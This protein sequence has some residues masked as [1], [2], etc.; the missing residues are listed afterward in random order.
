MPELQQATFAGGCFWCMEPPFEKLDGVAEVAAGYTGGPSTSLGAPSRASSRD[1]GAGRPTYEEVS[2]GATGH[3]EAVRITYDPSRVSY[4]ELLETFWRNIDPTQADGQFADKGSQYRT[5]IFYHTEEQRRL[6][7]ASKARLSGSG[8][9][10]QP[11]VTEVKPAGPF[12]PA[13]DYHQ[14]YHKK[15][16]LRYKLYRAG[17]G[18]EGYLQRTWGEPPHD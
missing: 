3:V 7:E 13:E 5:A 6:A 18:R 15:N 14:D 9:F 17:S 4:E 2:S 11:I 8:K 1:G 16:P 12:Y 10:D